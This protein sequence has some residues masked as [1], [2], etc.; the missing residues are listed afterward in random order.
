MPATTVVS[1]SA[2][3]RDCFYDAE[4]RE[5]VAIFRD[6]RMYRLRR[7]WLPEDDGSEIVRVRLESDGASFAV[8][9]SSGNRFEVPWDF[10]L[11][12]SDPRYQYYK[13][14]R[15]QHDTERSAAI[16]IGRRVRE[17]RQAKG[18][19][20]YE[21]AKR[22]RILRPNVSRIEGGK[23]VPNIDTLERLARGLSVSLSDLL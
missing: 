18:L 4:R 1:T 17:L 13:G 22:S 15:A 10:V 23:H 12:H 21:L 7:S 6:G 16:R 9:Q 2:K 20:T 11:Y 14:R 5:F 8:E 3:L 19:T